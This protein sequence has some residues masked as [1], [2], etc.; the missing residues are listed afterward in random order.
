MTAVKEA[1]SER[2]VQSGNRNN[3]TSGGGAGRDCNTRTELGS[4]RATETS[5]GGG[6]RRHK[7]E[8]GGV[9]Q[10]FGHGQ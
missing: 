8:L 4:G 6:G 3:G 7:E 9:G 10:G 1:R 5:D 2:E